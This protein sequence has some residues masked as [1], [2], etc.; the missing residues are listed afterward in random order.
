MR[1]QAR[2]RFLRS[3]PLIALFRAS[4]TSLVILGM[5][6]TASGGQEGNVRQTPLGMEISF[7][8]DSTPRVRF[9]TAGAGRAFIPRQR[10][11]INDPNTAG[12]FIGI[13]IWGERDADGIKVRLALIYLD[14][15]EID[16]GGRK[17]IKEKIV[18]SYLVR[19]GETVS[20]AELDRFGIEPFEM[21]AMDATPVVLKPGEGPRITDS[22][23]L[24]VERIEKHFDT[25][26]IRLKNKSDKNIVS[27]TVST[28]NGAMRTSGGDRGRTGIVLAAGATSE[29]LSLQGDEVERTGIKIPSII[30]EDGTFEGDPQLARQF[31]AAAEGVRIQSPAVLR[32]IEQTLKVDDSD[33]RAA[34]YK[35]EADLWVIPEAMYKQPA[36]QFLKAKFPDQNEKA[37]SSLYE[38]FK[39]G[40]YDAR[41]IALASLGDA[42][43]IVKNF[44][45]RSQ[46]ASAVEL[47][48]RT[49]ERLKETFGEITSAKQ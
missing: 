8:G 6:T 47:I 32:M 12:D 33:L 11:K 49:L 45:E 26:R 38:V 40:L 27:Y 24:E 19:V 37:L 35:L 16:G 3:A 41:N 9:N 4:L 42:G 31:L 7:P 28:G 29:E 5:L 23:V 15:E 10:L 1:T 25:Y 48:R 17:N 43:R 22:S 39:G 21:K 30:F 36:L 14:P 46:F 44:E 34:F 2:V 18:A 20:A 13:S